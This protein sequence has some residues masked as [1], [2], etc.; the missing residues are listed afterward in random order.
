MRQVFVQNV[1]IYNKLETLSISN[2]QLG[3][4]DDLHLTFKI[5][6]NWLSLLVDPT[7]NENEPE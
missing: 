3:L 6:I 4:I 7:D 1:W 5:D 2:N